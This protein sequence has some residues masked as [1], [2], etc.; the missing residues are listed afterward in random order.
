MSIEHHRQRPS[1]Q[2]PELGKTQSGKLVTRF[3]LAHNFRERAGN[4]FKDV[5][6]VL[7]DA[8]VWEEDGAAGVAELGLTSYARCVV[9]APV[10]EATGQ[11]LTPLGRQ[12]LFLRPPLP[13]PEPP[14]RRTPSNL[15]APS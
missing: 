5:A 4:Q 2:D 8:G 9:S 13:R 1:Y 11:K 12:A 10:T 7:F 15:G 3:G 14:V 6:T